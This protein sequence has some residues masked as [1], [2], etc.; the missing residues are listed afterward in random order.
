MVVSGGIYYGKSTNKYPMS[1]MLYLWY[2]CEK[3]TAE[4]R[5]VILCLFAVNSDGTILT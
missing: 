1:K 2:R 4:Q 5:I 3:P